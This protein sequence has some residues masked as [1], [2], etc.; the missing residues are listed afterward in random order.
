[1]AKKKAGLNVRTKKKNADVWSFAEGVL[2]SAVAVALGSAVLRDARIGGLGTSNGRIVS[3]L[4]SLNSLAPADVVYDAVT[5]HA[6]LTLAAKVGRAPTSSGSSTSSSAREG[7]TVPLMILAQIVVIDGNNLAVLQR[8]PITC[9]AML[10]RCCGMEGF[11]VVTDPRITYSMRAAVSAS[12]STERRRGA[13]KTLRACLRAVPDEVAIISKP[14]LSPLSSRRTLS[15]SP[16]GDT[17]AA[18]R[19]ARSKGSALDRLELKEE[20]DVYEQVSEDQ[21]AELVRQRRQGEDFVV[22]DDGLGY[23]D[24]GEEHL[25]EEDVDPAELG[26]GQVTAKR[27]TAHGADAVKKAKK[28]KEARRRTTTPYAARRGGRP[29]PKSSR[30]SKH[31]AKAA[32]PSEATL[33]A[34]AGPAVVKAEVKEE[35]AEDDDE[36]AVKQP[37]RMAYGDEDESAPAADPSYGTGASVVGGSTV[38][39]AKYLRTD[40]DGDHCWMY[41]LDAA[42]Q[43]GPSTSWAR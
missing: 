35:V 41:W 1:M 22:D 20:E 14:P 36:D 43:S 13:A 7:C 11:L 16:S 17:L 10:V 33:K 5:R 21:Y 12:S 15:K 26:R 4:A 25:G 3:F 38:D 34:L 23:F 2:A 42:E 39:E 40:D 19:D 29:K 28:L 9:A 8:V 27:T 32:G 6:A 31:A 37:E 24:D 30:F 18:L